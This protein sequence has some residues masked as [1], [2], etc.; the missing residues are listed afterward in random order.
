MA[1]PPIEVKRNKNCES[2]LGDSL[3]TIIEFKTEDETVLLPSNFISTNSYF[4]KDC[5]I[6]AVVKRRIRI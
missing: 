3:E 4:L 6:D 5:A 2:Q 1:L